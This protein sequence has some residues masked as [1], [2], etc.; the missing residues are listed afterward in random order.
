LPN[1]TKLKEGTAMDK[2]NK[3]Y[4]HVNVDSI[5]NTKALNIVIHAQVNLILG[6]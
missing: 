4:E 6:L 3:K 2:N 5:L 1:Y